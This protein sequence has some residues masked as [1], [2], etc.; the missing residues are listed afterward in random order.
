MFSCCSWS[1]LPKHS[2]DTVLVSTHW[3]SCVL[4]QRTY[5]TAKVDRPD[6]RR[7]RTEKEEQEEEEK[8]KWEVFGENLRAHRAKQADS[9]SLEHHSNERETRGGGGGRVGGGV[10][11]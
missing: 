2:S 3:T 11:A 6:G 10:Q 4:H 5:E 7:T 1:L 8:K 9:E